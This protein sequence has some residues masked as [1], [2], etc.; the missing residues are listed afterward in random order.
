[1]V[2]PVIPR[3]TRDSLKKT[4]VIPRLTRDPL[5][6]AEHLLRGLRVKPA[7][8]DTATVFSF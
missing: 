5:M 2:I 8:T 7:M 6:T 3:L 1:M 4:P